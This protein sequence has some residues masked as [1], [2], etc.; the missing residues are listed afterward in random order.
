MN[1]LEKILELKIKE[2]AQRQ[3]HLPLKKLLTLVQPTK[4]DFQKAIQGKKKI[5]LIAE[6][7]LASPSRGRF[8]SRFNA[9]ELADIYNQQ[10]VAA[11]SVLTDEKIFQGSLETLRLVK[12]R[13][14]PP[15]LRKDFI[16]DEY[17]I[18]ESL[19]F[20]ADAVLLIVNLICIRKLRLLLKIAARYNLAAI[21]EIHDLADLRKA[22][23]AGA[24]II[25]INNRNLKTL[26]V[27][28]RTSERLVEIIPSELT[29]VAES[30]FKT[31]YDLLSLQG[32]IDAVLVGRALVESPNIEEKIQFFMGN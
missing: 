15:V 1:F 6:I 17:Q 32:K 8:K 7:K 31:R 18:L 25:G 5:S 22:I 28:L 30:G 16:I 9:M 27:D 20:G 29:I 23:E 11:I 21:C 12:E 4:I 10:K 26:K 19:Y 14:S 3:K 13:V 24:E 2:V